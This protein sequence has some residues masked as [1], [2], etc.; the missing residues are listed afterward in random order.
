MNPYKLLADAA[1][2]F[3]LDT[4]RPCDYWY[5]E[6]ESSDGHLGVKLEFRCTEDIV[7][8]LKDFEAPRDVQ[9]NFVLH[10]GGTGGTVYFFNQVNTKL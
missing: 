4:F 8:H 2:S 1:R 10:E 6:F 3:V 5:G 7:E 9:V